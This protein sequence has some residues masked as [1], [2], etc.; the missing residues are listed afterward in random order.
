MRKFLFFAAPSIAIAQVLQAPYAIPTFTS[1]SS[2]AWP[3]DSEWDSLNRSVGG[4][5]QA[6]RPWAAREAVPAALLWSNWESCGYDQGC[7]LNYSNPQPISDATCYQGSTPPY[8]ISVLD[9]QDASM[10]V[11]WA[12]AHNTKVTV[13]NTGLLAYSLLHV[14]SVHSRDLGHDYLGRSA[15]PSTLQVYTHLMDNLSYVPEFVPRGS[16][17]SPV[18]ALTIG[19]GVQVYHIYNYAATNLFSPIVGDCLTVGAA[20]GYLQGGGHSMLTPA[21]G[22]AADNALEF[23]VVTA[24]GRIRVVNEAQNSDL[25]W[26]LRGGGAG[27]WGIVTSAT[28]RAHPP[29][30][31]VIS[32]LSVVPSAS[33]NVTTLGIEFISLL[34]KYQNGWTN[35]G[36][37]TIFY[38]FQ[39]QYQLSFYLPDSTA[40]LSEL[41]PFFEELKDRSSS[42]RVTSN[43]TLTFPTIS[44]AILQ[45]FGPYIDKS[46]PYGASNQQS[47]RLVPK[48][49]IDPS[50]SSSITAVSEAI[51]KGLQIVNQPLGSGGGLFGHVPVIILG[52]F[53]AATSH[54]VNTTGANPGLYTAAWLVFYA[55]SWTLG[56]DATTNAKVMSAIH[57]AVS[58]LTALGIKSSYQNEGDPFE[59]DWQQAFFGYKYAELSSIKL[60]YDP[61]NFFTSWKGVASVTDLPAYQC[62][63][64]QQN[65]LLNQ[66]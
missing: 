45:H 9:A 14:G 19:A 65:K 54:L 33:Q 61:Q 49:S 34:A 47:S 53:P 5:L 56:V 29:V 62:L 12:S 1:L 6:L 32:E 40:D 36:I 4:R 3:S 23:E 60:K 31:I 25:F 20:G 50:N 48:S 52:S 22:L 15:A 2:G 18:P 24:D 44:A 35:K 17:A 64:N 43:T 57:N 30:A 58:P 41:Y 37:A 55:A 38:L 63:M 39:D 16:D 7:A 11:K 27:S 10:V 8:S 42:Y 28:I 66:A 51:W 21:Y 59:A 46:T 26:A 13:K